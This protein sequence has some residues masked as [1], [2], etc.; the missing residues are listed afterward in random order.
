MKLFSI[1]GGVH[2]ESRKELSADSPI[3]RPSLPSLMRVPLCQHI[4]N[5]AEPV[6]GKGDYV[7]KGQLIGMARGAISAPVHAPTSGQ[8]IAI[9][10]FAAPHAS[11]LPDRTITLRPDGKDAWGTLPPPLDARSPT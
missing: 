10:R 11:G 4:G 8:V 5:A 6:V 7:L 2:P 1:R 9:G 3:D